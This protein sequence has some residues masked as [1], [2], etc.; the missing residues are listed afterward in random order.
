LILH[1]LLV[2]NDRRVQCAFP[3]YPEDKG[4]GMSFR[5]ASLVLRQQ[6]L[7]LCAV[8]CGCKTTCESMFGEQ[9]LLIVSISADHYRQLCAN[10]ENNRHDDDDVVQ[11]KKTNSASLSIHIE[12]LYAKGKRKTEQARC[13]AIAVRAL[14]HGSVDNQTQ[15]MLHSYTSVAVEF[16]FV[17]AMQLPYFAGV[18]VS[19]ILLANKFANNVRELFA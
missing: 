16:P 7:I 2:S 14:C 17:Y 18:C 9:F 4:K 8:Q 6:L 3:L 10:S 12:R 13:H 19:L 15:F 5:K 11:S 1:Q